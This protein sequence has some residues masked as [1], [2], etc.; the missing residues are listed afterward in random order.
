MLAESIHSV[1]ILV[2]FTV[3]GRIIDPDIAARPEFAQTWCSLPFTLVAEQGRGHFIE[4]AHPH[5]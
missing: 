4:Y 5:D 3:A 2:P 1:T